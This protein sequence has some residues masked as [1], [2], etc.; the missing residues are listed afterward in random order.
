MGI[1]CFLK[2]YTEAILSLKVEN[3]KRL[4]IEAILLNCENWK[5]PPL[6]LLSLFLT[7]KSLFSDLHSMTYLAITHWKNKN[8]LL[9]K[10]EPVYFSQQNYTFLK[11]N[12]MNEDSKKSW[13]NELPKGGEFISYFFNLIFFFDSDFTFSHIFRKLFKQTLH[14]YLNFISSFIHQ[15]STFY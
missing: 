1:S 3:K 8:L 13:M 6:T 9:Q 4:E 12:N 7:L 11:N 15:V 14:P 2:N 5:P 10:N